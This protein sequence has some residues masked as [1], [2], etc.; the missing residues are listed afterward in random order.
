MLNPRKW[1]EPPSCGAAIDDVYFNTSTQWYPEESFVTVTTIGT[2][3]ELGLWDPSALQPFNTAGVFYGYENNPL[4]AKVDVSAS[5]YALN[6]FCYADYLNWFGNYGPSTDAGALSYQFTEMWLGQTGDEYVAG[7]KNIQGRPSTP[8]SSHPSP[9]DKTGNEGRGILSNIETVNNSGSASSDA[10]IPGPIWEAAVGSTDFGVKVANQNGENGVTGFISPT[11]CYPY[12]IKWRF[13]GSGDGDASAKLV[14]SKKHWPGRMYPQLAIL[15]TQAIESKLDIFWETSTTGLIEELNTLIVEGDEFTPV[16]IANDTGA[17]LQYAQEESNG[18]GTY[19]FKDALGV[20][21]VLTPFSVSGSIVADATM[22]IKHVWCNGAD[23]KT[24][25]EII[26]S[27]SYYKI[28]TVDYF[29][30]CVPPATNSFEFVIEVVSPSPTFPQDGSVIT[31][32]INLGTFTL[33]NNSPSITTCPGSI[34]VDKSSVGAWPV[35]VYNTTAE[36]GTNSLA[37]GFRK[38]CGLSWETFKGGIIKVEDSG[39]NE[40]LPGPNTFSYSTTS[41]AFGI[42]MFLEENMPVGD[43]TVTLSVI[44]SGGLSNTCVFD[45]EVS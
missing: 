27:G 23:V 41:I 32:D 21:Q 12:H 40:I 35:S 37:F 3:V 26:P 18:L 38:Y 36:N 8:S 39:G 15:E 5:A 4:I 31:T 33:L 10:N 1:N 14:I 22:S 28:R 6:N 11:N 9:F 43:Y 19:I 20:D 7:S 17:S 29:A 44:D 25:F 2:G 16:R 24:R 45:L 42:E 13:T 34:V 30:Y